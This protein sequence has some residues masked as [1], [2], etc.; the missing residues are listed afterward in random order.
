MKRVVVSWVGSVLAMAGLL[1]WL[2]VGTQTRINSAEDVPIRAE[3]TLQSAQHEVSATALRGRYLLVYFGYTHC[4][5][6]CPTTLLLMMN[7]LKDLGDAAARIQPIFITVDPERDDAK[8]T[9]EYASH[10]GK[11]LLGLSGSPAAI[12][13]AADHF[14]VYYSKVEDK[15]SALGYTMDHSGFIYLMGPDGRYITHFPAT[16]SAQELRQ[17]IHH[18]ID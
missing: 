15:G 8:I 5:D 10:F 4:P 6:V 9:Q 14:K 16:V 1:L 17:G 11:N 7:A 18:A 13:A 2:A 3:F 12:Q